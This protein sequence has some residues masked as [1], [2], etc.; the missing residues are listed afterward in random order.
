M[1][2]V[3]RHRTLSAWRRA[4]GFNQEHAARVLGLS[5]SYYSKLE[6]GLHALPG[7]RAKRITAKTGVPLEVLVV[8]AA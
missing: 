8:A 6:R 1:T 4:N 3:T 5:Q 2:R 7:D